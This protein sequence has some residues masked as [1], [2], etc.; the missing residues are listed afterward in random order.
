MPSSPTGTAAEQL[1]TDSMRPSPTSS[2]PQANGVR[3]G[4]FPLGALS[5]P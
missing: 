4:V 3:G 1:L 2:G 5:Q